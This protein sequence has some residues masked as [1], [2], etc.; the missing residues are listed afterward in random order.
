ML[1]VVASRYDRHAQTFVSRHSGARLL[2]SEDLSS[3]GWRF[4]LGGKRRLLRGHRRRSGRLQGRGG[5]VDEAS[6]RVRR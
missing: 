4:E 6:L 2:T 3:R 5:S 1:V